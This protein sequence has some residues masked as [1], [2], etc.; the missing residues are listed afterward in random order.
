MNGRVVWLLRRPTGGTFRTRSNRTAGHV[1]RALERL[2]GLPWRLLR[3]AG[4]RVEQVP[5]HARPA[6]P[7]LTLV[8]P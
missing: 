2:T 5:V 1:R 6:K 7:R 3:T 8:R 4:W